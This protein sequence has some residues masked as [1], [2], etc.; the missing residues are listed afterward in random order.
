MLAV[1]SLTAA[2]ADWLTAD[3]LSQASPRSIYLVG[4]L[5]LLREVIIYSPIDIGLEFFSLDLGPQNR[6]QT[7]HGG[8][9]SAGIY[10][11]WWPNIEPTVHTIQVCYSALPSEWVNYFGQYNFFEKIV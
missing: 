1:L 2:E 7:I 8:G 3:W 5:A 6:L 9:L 11:R 4:G 10:G